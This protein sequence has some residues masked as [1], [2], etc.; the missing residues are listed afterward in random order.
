MLGAMCV[1]ERWAWQ[2]CALADSNWIKEVD[3]LRAVPIPARSFVHVFGL[4]SFS[5]VGHAGSLIFACIT[6]VARLRHR[7]E[8][9][10]RCLHL[11]R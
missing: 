2:K 3:G 7:S 9:D 8:G 6:T 11:V 5:I 10:F 1:V 4:M